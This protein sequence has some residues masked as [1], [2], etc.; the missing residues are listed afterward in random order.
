MGYLAGSALRSFD[1]GLAVR[2][3][4]IDE[5]EEE[6]LFEEIADLNREIGLAEE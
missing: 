6:R 2:I 5:G 3:I 4:D 1:D